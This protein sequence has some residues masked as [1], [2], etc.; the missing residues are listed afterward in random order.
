MVNN[1]KSTL[2]D[3]AIKAGVSTGS[4]SRYINKDPS[5]SMRMSEDIEQA[6]RDLY[7]TPNMIAQ[8]L[9]KG[10]S[11]VIQLYVFHE[12]PAVSTSWV[13]ELVLMQSI[14]MYLRDT[15]YTLQIAFDSYLEVNNSINF[16]RDCIKGKNIDGVLIFS[17]WNINRELIEMLQEEEF[18][19]VLVRTRN[20]VSPN[21]EV[22]FDYQN[23]YSELVERLYKK[24]HRNFAFFGGYQ[25]RRRT[26]DRYEGF[27]KACEKLGLP[28]RKEWIKY[29]NYSME[30]GSEFYSELGT[31]SEKPT[32][33]ICGND[34]IA[35]GVVKAANAAN[36]SHLIEVTGFGDMD[37]AKLLSPPITTVKVSSIEIGRTAIKMLLD[38]IS[39]NECLFKSVS[40]PCEICHPENWDRVQI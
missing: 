37:I 29:G 21:N 32:A 24:G 12:D 22:Y 15:Q 18:P 5:L 9:A 35:A 6:M 19:F 26:A 11:N 2:K 23:V 36:E 30:S 13:N 38:I 16:L 39:R 34:T 33:I 14:S 10:R 31:L 3:V 40:L 17:S 7:Y 28:L 1:R 25:N 20:P 8:R 4:V 27:S